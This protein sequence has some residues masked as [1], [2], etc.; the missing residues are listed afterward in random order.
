MADLYKKS[1]KLVYRLTID[2][3]LYLIYHS[4]NTHFFPRNLMTTVAITDLFKSG[5]ISVSFF[6]S[7]VKL[8]PHKCQIA[9][10]SRCYS[11]SSSQLS[12]VLLLWPIAVPTVFF[13]NLLAHSGDKKDGTL[14]TIKSC[15]IKYSCI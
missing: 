11:C 1:S 14:K 12:A 8:N 13:C 9:L 5:E 15:D 2:I 6:A 4:Y 10:V 3:L 7:L